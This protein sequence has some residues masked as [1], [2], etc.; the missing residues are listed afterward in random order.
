[1]KDLRQDRDTVS[2]VSFKQT[3]E[4]DNKPIFEDNYEDQI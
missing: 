2:D 3:H 4:D 1:M